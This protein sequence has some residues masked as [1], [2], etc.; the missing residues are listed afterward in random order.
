MTADEYKRRA[1]E[2]LLSRG[3]GE[4]TPIE[5]DETTWQRLKSMRD[6]CC[7]VCGEYHGTDLPC[8]SMQATSKG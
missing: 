6:G 4:R 2:V 5:V 3:T 1:D 7:M 8:P